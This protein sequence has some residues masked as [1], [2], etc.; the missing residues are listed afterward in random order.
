MTAVKRTVVAKV[1]GHSLVMPAEHP[2]APTL[3]AFPQYNRPLGQALSAVAN[4]NPTI[5]LLGVID[6]GANVGD[7]VAI[8]EQR[9]PGIC[10]YLCIEADKDLARLCIS[11]HSDNKRV[12]VEQSFIGENEGSLVRLE[13]DGRANPSTKLATETA[14]IHDGGVGR[15][16]RLDTIA[17]PFAHALGHLDLIKVDTEGYDFSVL[18]SAPSLLGTYK[19]ALFFEWFPKLLL[20]LNEEVWDGFEYLKQFGYD[21]F[22][23]FTNQGDYYCKVTFP[24]RLLLQSFASITTNGGPLLYF[25]V[26]ATTSELIC[27]E[28]VE[29]AVTENL[30]APLV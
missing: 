12:H 29:L 9:R 8:L 19:P 6:V 10:S 22:V 30:P 23:F 3:I 4:V 27:N 28:L 5:S 24:D 13:D 1:Y 21:Y 16:V 14:A 11:N 2:L 7:T 26:F 17:L 25:D 20:G 15:L 18:R